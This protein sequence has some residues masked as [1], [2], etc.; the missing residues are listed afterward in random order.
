MK[1]IKEE[2]YERLREFILGM[3]ESRGEFEDDGVVFEIYVEFHYEKEWDEGF[4]YY[5]EKVID[6]CSILYWLESGE[7][8]DFD[9]SLIRLWEFD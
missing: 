2:T 5:A 1:H 7:E 6:C 9:E 4:G 8:T 3:D